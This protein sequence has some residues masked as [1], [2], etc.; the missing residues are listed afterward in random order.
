MTTH[1]T[2][3]IFYTEVNYSTAH[4]THFIMDK[5]LYANKKIFLMIFD[6]DKL[7]FLIKIF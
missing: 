5:C 2:H 3:Y 1:T 4:T 7:N 6:V